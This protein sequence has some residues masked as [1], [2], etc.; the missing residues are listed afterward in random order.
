MLT[1]H[2][3]KEIWLVEKKQAD[4]MEYSQSYSSNDLYL[5]DKIN[6]VSIQKCDII[7]DL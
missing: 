7:F 4:V 1:V 3:F 6:D 5:F 2:W